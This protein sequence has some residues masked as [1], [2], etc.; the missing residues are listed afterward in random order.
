MSEIR[1][2]EV[3][4]QAREYT[5]YPSARHFF[6]SYSMSVPRGPQN[7]AAFCAVPL[8]LRCFANL[9]GMRSRRIVGS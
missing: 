8:V 4:S 2:L 6:S 5:R 3:D 7:V 1:N 9:D